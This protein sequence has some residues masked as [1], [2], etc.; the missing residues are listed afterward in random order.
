MLVFTEFD[1]TQVNDELKS[2]EKNCFPSQMGRLFEWFVNPSRRR[3][4]IR[5]KDEKEIRWTVCV[6]RLREGR[7]VFSTPTRS[8]RFLFCVFFYGRRLD[9]VQHFVHLSFAQLLLFLNLFFFFGER[10][11]D[12][13]TR[14]DQMPMKCGSN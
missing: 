8:T 11:R 7:R 10:E 1:Q 14:D 12:R 4:F 6:G 13:R 9:A 3:R 5:Q 2:R